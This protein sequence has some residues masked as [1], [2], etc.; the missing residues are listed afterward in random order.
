MIA[1]NIK[2]IRQE[3]GLTQDEFADKLGVSRSVIANLEYGRL[4]NPEKKMPLF[5]LISK[6]FEIP[7]EWILADDPGDFPYPTEGKAA[8]AA[9]DAFATD[10]VVK[11]FMEFWSQRTDD[12]KKVLQQAIDAFADALKQQNK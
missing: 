6:T 11:S 1:D 9:G 7:V 4:Q 8:A 5:R 2:K 3:Y 10:P 12:E